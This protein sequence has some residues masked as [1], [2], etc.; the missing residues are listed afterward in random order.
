MTE[1]YNRDGKYP[2][3]EKMLEIEKRCTE[4]IST[5][6][7]YIKVIDIS[8]SGVRTVHINYAPT[9]SMDSGIIKQYITYNDLLLYDNMLTTESEFN[10]AVGEILQDF[11]IL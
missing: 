1:I 3:R 5:I 11:N 7:G 9:L 10:N 6:S 8:F 2:S 4:E